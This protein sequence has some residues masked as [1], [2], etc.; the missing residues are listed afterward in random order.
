MTNPIISVVIGSFQR[1]GFIQLTIKSIR[2]ELTNI[3]HEIIVVDGGSTDG[4]LQWLLNQK[5]IITITQHNRGIWNNLPIIQR[6]WGYFMNLGFKIAQGKYVC[7]LSDDCIVIPNSL[8]NGINLFEHSLIN[9]KQNV[10]ALAFYWRNWP[11][12]TRYLVGKTWGDKIFVNHG[13]YLHQALKEVGYVDEE[14]YSF[15]HADGDLSLKIHE[16]GYMIIDC[17]I[18]FIEH[19]VDANENIRLE[20]LK[21]QKSDWAFYKGK[22]EDK[23]GAPIQDWIELDYKDLTHSA[24]LFKSAINYRNTR[25]KIYAIR[26]YFGI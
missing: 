5:D 3:S 25:R 18:S 13:M 15:Y 24:D 10:G 19:Y 1:N 14:N 20:N 17:P 23:L 9:L 4:S 6:S 11:K 8:T 22:W 7:M 26:K 2:A 16:M 12:E 21:T